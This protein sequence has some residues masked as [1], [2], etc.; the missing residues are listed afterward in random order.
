MLKRL[1]FF[2]AFALCLAPVFAADKSAERASE[3]FLFLYD[4][5]HMTAAEVD[6]AGRRAEAA[7]KAV[8]PLF[9]SVHYNDKITL[10]LDAEFRG[11]TGYAAPGGK[12]GKSEKDFIGLRYA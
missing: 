2:I 3:H 4:P 11:A 9:P 8:A 12:S 10:R 5:T 1:I 6:E 7:L